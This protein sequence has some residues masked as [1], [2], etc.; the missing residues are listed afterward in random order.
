MPVS[1]D[2]DLLVGFRENS[3]IHPRLIH[4]AG[5]VSRSNRPLLAGVKQ[6]RRLCSAIHWC[7]V[8]ENS[9]RH[10]RGS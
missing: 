5:G 2:E 1:S 6:N 8:S 7:K 10:R 4:G 3:W 9:T